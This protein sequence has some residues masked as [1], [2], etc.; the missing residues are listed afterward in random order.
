M[1][2]NKLVR[3]KEV[4]FFMVSFLLFVKMLHHIIFL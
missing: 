3:S 1:L 2:V 4:I